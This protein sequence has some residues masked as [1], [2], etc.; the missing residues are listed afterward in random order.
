M[1]M[2]EDKSAH[3]LD[4]PG[5]V[6]VGQLDSGSSEPQGSAGVEVSIGN[7]DSSAIDRSEQTDGGKL[8]VESFVKFN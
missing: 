1:D 6:H 7:E 5:V 8:R 2:S 3:L 4:L